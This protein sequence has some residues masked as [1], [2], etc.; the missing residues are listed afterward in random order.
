MARK[1]IED[2][3]VAQLIHLHNKGESC[4]S[5]GHKFDI[6]PRTVKSHIEKAKKIHEK[7]HWEAVSRQVDAKYLDEHYR[8]LI[9]MASA[10]IDIIR[11]NPMNTTEK[12][13]S[14]VYFDMCIES[15]THKATQFLAARGFD[16]TPE[17]KTDDSPVRRLGHKLFNAL[18]EHEPQLKTAIDA[19]ESDW[20]RF[21]ER[22]LKLMEEARNLLISSNIDDAIAKRIKR[23]IVD[24]ALKH[25]LLGDELCSS[26]V[27]TSDR[28]NERVQN[29]NSRSKPVRLVR[30]NKRNKTTVYRGSK[31]EVAAICKV[32]DKTL[33][34]LYHEERIRPIRDS[35]LS[36][37]KR[38]EEIKDYV[39]RLILVGRPQGRCSL[40]LNQPENISSTR[41]K[42]T[43]RSNE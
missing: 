22:R 26:I 23:N 28:A 30:D 24:E 32:Y 8:M 17:L 14:P 2:Q 13:P 12:Q 10:I 15:A 11:P 31:E 34:Q 37:M 38:I 25:K 4:R 19:W 16:L 20:I 21:Q 40:C 35:H 3:M 42:Y 33:I 6:D 5:I 43:Q 7:E 9:Q 27:D 39:D 29:T 36:L 1:R 18:I 41:T